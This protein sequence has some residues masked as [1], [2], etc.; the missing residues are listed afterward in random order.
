LNFPEPSLSATYFHLRPSISSQQISLSVE[1]RN[2]EESGRACGRRSSGGAAREAL[3]RRVSRE[4][5]RM[6]S[7]E[8][9][10]SGEECLSGIL[11]SERRKKEEV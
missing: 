10:G 9:M 6:E 7:E 5:R 1:R 8:D 3:M 11:V 2:W 4:R